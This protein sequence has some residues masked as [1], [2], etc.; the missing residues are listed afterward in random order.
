MILVNNA[1][2]VIQ[3]LVRDELRGRVMSLY[4]LTFLG[5]MPLGALL[6]GTAAELVGE[7]VAVALGALVSLACATVVYV[8]VPRLRSL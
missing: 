5:F 8:R 6:A 2:V 4:A 7:P 3:T 1:N